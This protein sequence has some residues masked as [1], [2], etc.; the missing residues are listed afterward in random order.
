MNPLDPNNQGDRRRMHQPSFLDKSDPN[1]KVVPL[2]N[3][4]QTA[5]NMTIED[6]S[7]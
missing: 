1:E 2:K 3:I 6:R 4:A 5:L 7:L